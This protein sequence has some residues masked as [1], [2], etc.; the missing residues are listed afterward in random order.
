MTLVQTTNSSNFMTQMVSGTAEGGGGISPA[1][2]AWMSECPDFASFQA[3]LQEYMWMNKKV[4]CYECGEKYFNK[5]LR[6]DEAGPCGDPSKLICRTC[7]EI[8]NEGTMGDP[9]YRPP[10]WPAKLDRH[11]KPSQLVNGAIFH[12]KTKTFVGRVEGY[13]K[14]GHFAT[15]VILNGMED[16]AEGG[17]L[18]PDCVVVPDESS[19]VVEEEEKDDSDDDDSDDE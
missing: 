18:D 11:T 4:G 14:R 10:P 3:A 16:S 1:L 15:R 19:F 17:P 8:W 7:W 5:D 9:E 13:N 2:A 6:Y 12:P